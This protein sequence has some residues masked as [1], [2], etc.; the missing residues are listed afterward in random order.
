KRYSPEAQMRPRLLTTPPYTAYLRIAD[1]CD[2]HCTYCLIPTL[3][4]P[5]RSRYIEDILQEAESL[6]QS[7]V[8]EINIIAQDTTGYGKDIYGEYKLVELLE[9]IEEIKDIHWIRLLYTYPEEITEELVQ[10]LAKSDKICHYLDIPLQHA[11]DEILR[12]MG[13]KGRVDNIRRLIKKLRENIPDITLRTTFIVGFPGETDKHFESLYRF[14][15]ETKFDRLG[16]FEY[17]KE[18]GTAAAKMAGQVEPKVKKERKTRVRQLQAR[19]SR[20]KNKA[21][22]GK[23]LEVLFT[24]TTG[25]RSLRDAPD[26]DGQILCPN[27]I[28]PGTFARVQICHA[29]THDLKGK[30]VDTG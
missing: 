30:L 16:V 11:D 23:I 15:E 19:I 17:S 29:L 27:N 20:M 5:Y 28:T 6:A 3:R 7:G 12:K 25:G 8:K 4:G 1:G 26:I 13:R 2:N 18:K 24:G 10:F 21:Y 9:R 22:L 14:I